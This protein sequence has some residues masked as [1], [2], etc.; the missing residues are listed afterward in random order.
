MK[1]YKVAIVGATGAV[2][3]E[4]LRMLE[5]RNFP[6]GSLRLF[7]SSRSKGRKLKFKNEEIEVEELTE[8]IDGE[9]EITLFSAGAKV[10]KEFCPKFVQ[11]NSFVIDNS[12]AWRMEP[13]IPLIVPEVN[14]EKVT[15]QTKLIS[16]PNCSTIQ[17]VLVLAPIHRAVGITR[18]VVATYQSVSGAGGLAMQELIEQTKAVIS[19]ETPPPPKKIPHRIA[20]NIVP[21]IDV[22]EKNQYTKEEMKMVNETKKIL[23]DWDIKISAT[24]ARV[25]VLRGHSE[26]V[27]IETKNK[28]SPQEIKGLLK[29]QKNIEVLDDADKNLYPMPI[30]AEGKVTTYVGRIREDLSCENGVVMWIVSDNLLKGAAF[31]AIQIAELLLEK[32]IL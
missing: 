14:P 13:H 30:T 31:N 9:F 6:V 5:V 7:A 10:S 22:F 3:Q 27:W 18:I 26:A 23:N 8:N 12:S 29:N 15:N 24:C 16:N 20:F 1:K 25:P 11:M 19:G 21:Q 2:G 32:K 28:I 17:M 4:M